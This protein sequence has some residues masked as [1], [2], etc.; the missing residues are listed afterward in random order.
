[1]KRNR[2]ILLSTVLL[3]CSVSMVFAVSRTWDGEGGDGLWSTPANW[4]GNAVPGASDSAILTTNG[5]GAAARRIVLTEPTNTV[6]E[7]RFVGESDDVILDG[8]VIAIKDG[9]PMP[10]QSVL[11]R[12]RRRL[13]P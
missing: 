13:R 10:F 5:F 7:L 9:K 4:S 8:E 1:M 6:N 3:G 12:F 11:R 2:A